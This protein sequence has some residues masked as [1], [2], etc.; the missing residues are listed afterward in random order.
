MCRTPAG[1]MRAAPASRTRAR[2]HRLIFPAPGHEPLPALE[3]R[4]HRRRAR[5]RHP[6][7]AAQFLSRS[8]GGA[9]VVGQG[10]GR[11]RGCSHG[12]G[13]AQG[14]EHPIPRRGARSHRHQGALRRPRHPAQGQGRAAGQ[15]G[16][17]L[18]RRAQPPVLVAALAGVDRRAADVPRPRPARRR[19]LPAAGRH[20]GGARQGGRPLHGRPPLAAA[21]GEGP[22]LGHRR[23]KARTW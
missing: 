13:G 10:Q 7:H 3:I 4:R 19:V 1:R 18:H 12:R 16:R 15:A 9:G 5:G 2:R 23:A 21:Q 20:E 14:G 17:E 22:V 8:A 6:V 11:Q